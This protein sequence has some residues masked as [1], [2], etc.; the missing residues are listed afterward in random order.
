MKKII[1]FFGVLVCALTLSAKETIKIGVIFPLSGPMAQNGEDCRDAVLMRL[2]EQK[3]KDAKFNYQAIFEDDQCQPRQTVEAFWKLK[4]I[5]HVDMVMSLYSSPSAALAPIANYNKVLH[6]GEG[7]GSRITIRPYSFNNF[8]KGDSIALKSVELCQAMGYKRVAMLNV[9][10]ASTPA[11]EKYFAQYAPSHGLEI[12][13]IQHFNM[14][15]KDFRVAIL[16]IREA[17]PDVLIIQAF[18]PEAS[19]IRRQMK[20]IA[21]NVPITAMCMWGNFLEP[22]YFGYPYVEPAAST[23]FTQKFAKIYKHDGVYFSGMA[24]D[25]VGMFIDA[26]EQY[27]GPGKPPIDFLS[28]QLISL[29]DYPGV[30]G[31]LTPDADGWFDYPPAIVVQTPQGRKEITME[32]AVKMAKEKDARK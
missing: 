14:P 8:S 17:K 31:K 12:V 4:A 22:D 16:K 1:F 13:S 15:E 3:T 25:S 24:Y 23:D 29:K 6:I 18:D 21:F 20:E 2:N 32:E 5:D 7:F 27:T 19:I 28:K 10:F 9:M 30:M 11:Q 26:C